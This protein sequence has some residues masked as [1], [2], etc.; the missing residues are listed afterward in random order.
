[1]ELLLVRAIRHADVENDAE[2]VGAIPDRRWAESKH[3]HRRDVVRRPQPQ[4]LG[5]AVGQLVR[6]LGAELPELF[7]A[8]VCQ[9][10]LE[11]A[12]QHRQGSAEEHR[13]SWGGRLGAQSGHVHRLLVVVIWARPS[14][15]VVRGPVTVEPVPGRL[16][17][18][19]VVR[20]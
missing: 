20:E 15:T 8:A 9:A 7:A 10:L 19:L 18:V 12:V 11:W 16:D 3:V 4:P 6:E 17:V 2:R 13:A 1:M 14:P 5:Q